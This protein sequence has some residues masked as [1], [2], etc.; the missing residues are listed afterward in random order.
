MI[1]TD[2][3]P[4]ATNLKADFICLIDFKNKA[5]NHYVNNRSNL[6]R[7]D[8]PSGTVEIKTSADD[9][10]PSCF[11]QIQ[12]YLGAKFTYKFKLNGKPISAKALS[13]L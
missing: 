11:H 5:S 6:L 10:H 13:S 8:T 9:T 12:G 1:E 4:T 3:Q 2:T 7:I